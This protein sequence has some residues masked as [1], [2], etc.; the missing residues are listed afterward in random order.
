MKTK[1]IENNKIIV[2]ILV[3]LLISLITL[4]L[5]SRYVGTIGIIVK[6]YKIE[7]N[8][9]PSNFSGVKIVHFL[10]LYFGNT[11]NEN[12]LKKINSAI[13]ELKPDL[14]LFTGNLFTLDY[15]MSEKNKKILID[16]LSELNA[17]IGKYAVKGS[18]DF[19]IDYETI[20]KESDFILL[21]NTYDIIYFNGHE[22][23]FL[24]GVPSTSKDTL[25]LNE[26]FKYY[27]GAE[28]N[29]QKAKY[30]II[31]SSEGNVFEK[32]MKYD[33]S[34][35]LLLGSASLGGS[36]IIPF[37]GPLFIPKNT[38]KYY[39]PHYKLE[40]KEIF[41]SSGIGT[42]NIKFRFNNRPSI[43]LYRLKSI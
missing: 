35:N 39:A 15:N 2:K 26:L 36:V 28:E 20:L 5:Y 1:E 33:E 34:V 21:N 3:L 43:N 31:I 23:I 18:S 10:D 25:N 32:I 19:K 4:V 40:N 14:I 41:I 29:I 17:S 7:S 9:I 8:V 30:K 27:K 22:P 12:E 24:G 38:T 16:F 37:Y 13:N 11:T 42:N 6:E